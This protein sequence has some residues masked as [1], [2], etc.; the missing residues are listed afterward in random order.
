MSLRAF[1]LF[2]I[3]LSVALAAFVAAWASSQY[4]MEQEIG[5][6]AAAFAAL[7]AGVVLAIYGARFQRRTKNL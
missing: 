6:A 3:A 2:F 4:R 5:Y 7:G 1:H